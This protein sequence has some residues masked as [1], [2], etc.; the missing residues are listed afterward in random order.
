L[1]EHD[2]MTVADLEHL[3]YEQ[4]GLKGLSGVSSDMLALE[5]SDAPRA[6]EAIDYFAHRIRMEIGA[7]ASTL[8]GLD[9]L[10]FTGGIGEHSARVRAAVL[11]EMRWLGLT[12]DSKAN[13]RGAQR[14]SDPA[15][16]TPVF[17]LATDEEAMIAHHTIKT[18]GLAR[19]RAA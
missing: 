8:Q 18:A 15:A 5:A 14:I 7:L 13:A 4:S 12:V 11:G 1:L 3:L 19:A 2:K 6:R 10:V 16:A 9:A 17:A